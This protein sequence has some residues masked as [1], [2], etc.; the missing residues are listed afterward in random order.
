MQRDVI[1]KH[2]PFF[3]C[4]TTSS[5]V[6]IHQRILTN[7][8][9]SFFFFDTW[10]FSVT[11]R[12]APF[13]F[14]PLF[15]RAHIS[16][17]PHLASCFFFTRRT[18]QCQCT[19]RT[20][21]TSPSHPETPTAMVILVRPSLAPLRPHLRLSPRRQTAHRSL[22]PAS[23]PSLLSALPSCLREPSLFVPP[24]LETLFHVFFTVGKHEHNHRNTT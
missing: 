2:S 21:S 4:P 9:T 8:Q 11:E 17:S 6:H 18:T 13:F 5:C 12:A 24:F 10:R 22:S 1:S 20:A 3:L 7:C 14:S 23:L 16:F 15:F 19:R